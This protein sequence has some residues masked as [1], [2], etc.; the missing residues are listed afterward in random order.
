M[1]RSPD[2]SAGQDEGLIR[3]AGIL[4]ADSIAAVTEP[5]VYGRKSWLREVVATAGNQHSGAAEPASAVLESG[6]VAALESVAPTR[7][8]TD[9]QWH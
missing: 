6:G 7:E 1:R 3:N 4:H 8:A 5:S 2:T 9:S